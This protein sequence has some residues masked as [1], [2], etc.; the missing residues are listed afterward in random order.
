MRS[1]DDCFQLPRPD[2]RKLQRALLALAERTAAVPS[3]PHAAPK[4]ASN[5]AASTVWARQKDDKLK[6]RLLVS[7]LEA[8]LAKDKVV[9]LRVGRALKTLCRGSDDL[10][11]VWSDWS[12]KGNITGSILP[13]SP[14]LPSP[15]LSQ[16]KRIQR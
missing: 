6:G 3:E 14:N 9:W 13:L 1:D 10:L 11:G 5:S 8:S 7:Q 4:D 2:Y 15:P 16:L 12:K